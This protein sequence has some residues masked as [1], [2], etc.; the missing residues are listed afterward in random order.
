MINKE[1]IAE[2]IGIMLGDGHIGIYK[3][4]QQRKILHQLKVTL[5]SRNKQYTNFV[6][7]LM[8]RVLDIKP[9]IFYK[10][11][12]NAVDIKVYRKEKVLY[13]LNNLKLKLSPKMNKATIPK[14]YSKG[15]I[16][17]S[18]LKGLFDTDGSVTIFNNNGIR[19]PRIEIRICNSPMQQQFINIL[20]ENK[21]KHK[22]QRFDR[23]IK[24]RISGKK[25]LQKWFK[26]VGSS[27]NL[28]LTRAA[29]FLK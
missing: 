13:A 22:I 16:G 17:L 7:K 27:N 1:E 23:G 15:K 19:Y 25:E 14:D 12:E 29:P 5:D 6:A 21:I 10:K 9:K 18:V 28:Y 26:K 4:K 24:I 3:F 11:N 8:E 2:F 20:D